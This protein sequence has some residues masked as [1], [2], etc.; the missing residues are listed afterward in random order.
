MFAIFFIVVLLASGSEPDCLGSLCDHKAKRKTAK[1]QANLPF[2]QIMSSSDAM[3]TKQPKLVLVTGAN[4]Y[5]G[6]S[7]I[8]TLLERGYK[9]RGT[10]RDPTDKKLTSAVQ[11]FPNA[12]THLELVPLELT[13]ETEMFREAL[14]GGVEWIMHVASP[15]DQT[16]TN[17]E[18]MIRPAVEGTLSILR[19]A[20]VTPS[21]T[22]VVLTSSM[23]AVSSGHD[24]KTTFSEKDWSN[25]D[26]PNLNP[27]SKS[28]T[29]AERAAWEFMAS[30]ETTFTLS[31]INP[32]FVLGPVP[33]KDVST[34]TEIISQIM[35][36]GVPA[37]HMLCPIVDIRDVVEAHIQAA[38]IPEAA[39]KRF[40]LTNTDDGEMLYMSDISTILAKEFN[41]R[42]YN[43]KTNIVPRWILWFMSFFDKTLAFFYRMIDAT[44][45]FD[46]SQSKDILKLKYDIPARQTILDGAHSMIEQGVIPKQPGYKKI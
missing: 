10:V 4:G 18:V 30:H 41:P 21:V 27:Y 39:G 20:K 38:L 34:S 44:A 42:G 1:R 31:A 24:K 25:L 3:G 2:K 9:V 6:S 7:L 16:E 45:H 28:K 8:K 43:I 17:D 14:K 33:S 26:G 36:A 40:L 15:C 5:I 32:S 46:N 23:S 29:L 37:F 12:S 19:A 22:K 35:T 11:A 13:G